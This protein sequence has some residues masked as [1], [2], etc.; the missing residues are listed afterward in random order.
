MA[1]FGL[2]PHN[3]QLTHLIYSDRAN[4]RQVRVV[5]DFNDW[6]APGV[7]MI[8]SATGEGWT[9]D[10]PL[11]AG[12]YRYVYL[13]NG[14]TVPCG[15][16]F[17]SQVKVIVIAP[18]DYSLFP[19]KKGD[20]MITQ[21]GVAHED[22]PKFV[23][24]LN[25]RTYSLRLRT[26][27]DDVLAEAVSVWSPGK[28]QKNYPMRLV[29]SDPL[30]DYYEVKIVVAPRARFSYRFLLDDGDGIQTYDQNGLNPGVLG[31]DP[32]VIGPDDYLVRPD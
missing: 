18:D 1:P 26:R 14:A 16:A 25:A 17:D 21:S 28:D 22:T 8:P 20:G 9:L 24:R 5:G 32:F 15:K 10:L 30:F 29:G 2:P 11:A 23:K 31:N 3:G 27:K 7:K 12:V 6:S 13:P 4:V 19:A